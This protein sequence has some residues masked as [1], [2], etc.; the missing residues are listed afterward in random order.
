M[1]TPVATIGIRGTDYVVVL[2][3]PNI[4]DDPVL[5]DAAGAGGATGGVVVGVIQGGV[6]VANADGKPHELGA[7]HFLLTLPDGSIIDLPFDP[8]FIRVDPIPN[9]TTLC[10]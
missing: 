8:Q 6:F 10:Q 4:A 5:A 3:D 1:S 2:V 9:P 7:G